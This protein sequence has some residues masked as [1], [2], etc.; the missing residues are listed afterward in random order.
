[1]T[2]AAVVLVKLLAFVGLAVFAVVLVA[3]LRAMDAADVRPP[4][5]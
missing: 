2:P 3:T 1:M 5:E 4:E